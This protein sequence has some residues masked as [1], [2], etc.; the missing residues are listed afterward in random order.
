VI[1]FKCALECAEGSL[2][3]GGTDRIRVANECCAW[4]WEVCNESRASI[5]IKDVVQCGFAP[6]HKLC[7][8]DTC[9]VSQGVLVRRGALM[10]ILT[11]LEGAY[12]L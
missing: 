11:V 4:D 9:A 10:R 2:S 5:K 12:A 6:L 7:A 8:K 3:G 1:G